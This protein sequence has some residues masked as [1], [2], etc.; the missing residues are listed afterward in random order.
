[1]AL[2]SLKAVAL[3]EGQTR[4]T[5][6]VKATVRNFS[7]TVA[8]TY[9]H[10]LL[11]GDPQYDSEVHDHVSSAWIMGVILALKKSIRENRISFSSLFVSAGTSYQEN[12]TLYSRFNLCHSYI[13]T[14]YAFVIH[15]NL[16][17]LMFKMQVD[18]PPCCLS[19]TIYTY[20]SQYKTSINNNTHPLNNSAESSISCHTF[21]E[22]IR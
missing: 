4:Q 15:Y 10:S 6:G 22:K 11:S 8:H 12:R 20:L 7:D 17:M 1:M 21:S 16:S 19:C 14:M 5:R 3:T 9:P 2:Y 18:S 13:T